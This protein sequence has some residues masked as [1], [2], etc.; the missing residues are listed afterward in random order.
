MGGTIPAGFVFSRASV[1][2]YFNSSGVLQTAAVDAPRFDYNPAP[3]TNLL[4]N[5]TMQGAVVGSPG[6][7]PDNW[8]RNTTTGTTSD[9]TGVSVEGGINYVEIHASGTNGSATSGRITM[10]ASGTAG[11]P[12]TPGASYV[13]SVYLRL[14]GGSWAGL[15]LSGFQLRHDY[16]DAGNVL[17]DTQL[18]PTISPNN[19]PLSGQRYTFTTTAPALGVFYRFSIHWVPVLDAAIDYTF[20]IG[21]P[22]FEAGSTA[23]APIA[24]SNA[25]ASANE[26][27]GLLVEDNRTNSI[28]NNTMVGAVVGSPDL[29][30][31]GYFSLDPIS[32]SQ[33]TQLN[34]WEWERTAGTGTAVW[35]GANVTLTGD[36]SNSIRI[37]TRVVTVPGRI[38]MMSFSADNANT[39]IVIGTVKNASDLA[40]TN[41]STLTGNQVTFTASTT[42]AWIMFYKISVG[43]T[44]IDDVAVVETQVA[45]GDFAV[46]PVNAAQ[47]T[48]Q[49]GWQW[50]R[51]A[52][53]STVTWA[54]GQVTITPDGTNNAWLEASFATVVGMTYAV[55]ADVATN[56]LACTVGTV[57]GSSSLLSASFTPGPTKRGVF[58]A[59]TTTTW[60]RFQ[61]SAAGATVFDN[62]AVI[63][64][65]TQPTNWSLLYSMAANGMSTRIVGLSTESGITYVDVNLSGISDGSAFRFNMEPNNAIPAAS[66]QVWSHAVYVSLIAGTMTGIS[67]I[68]TEVREF[69]SGVGTVQDSTAFVPTVGA[70]ATRRQVHIRTLTDPTTTHIQP[71]FR[72]AT[73]ASAY[74]DAT[75]RIGMPQAEQGIF[76]TSVIPTTGAAVDR[77]ADSCLQTPIGSWYRHLSPWT[78]KVKCQINAYG[79]AGTTMRFSSIDDGTGNNRI[80]LRSASAVGLTGVY[81][82]GAG[83]LAQP[84]AAGNIVLGTPFKLASSNDGALVRVCLNGGAVNNA[85]HPGYPVAV[86]RA[87]IGMAYI[88]SSTNGWIQEFEYWPR[89]MLDAELQ[90]ITA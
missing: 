57:Q 10:G 56:T 29:V 30:T 31:N 7:M 3:R 61:R 41:T 16:Y 13:A 14:T 69:A 40:N 64:A 67:S 21:M 49:N 63:A 1:G 24:T 60:I 68:A 87:S 76:P 42:Q 11:I 88:P 43:S 46:S 85:A 48:P 12:V 9:T 83:S 2:T 17:I 72:L 82:A 66:G 79:S 89:G 78:V 53:T 20:R 71:A 86:T 6:T 22:Q 44:V 90:A 55:A 51:T 33:S 84:S 34:G 35:G 74:I 23:T 75:I 18:Q 5:N 62:V 19:S 45:N 50:S 73:T 47:N 28:R 37:K 38:Y 26:L 65:G 15:N 36:G 39:G 59:T 58:T 32:P 77:V 8:S 80:T 70:L 27:R 81:T 25:P 52:G 4:P 54:A